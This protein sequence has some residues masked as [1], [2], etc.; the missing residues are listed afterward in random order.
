MSD[1]ITICKECMDYIKQHRFGMR[2]DV[3]S[4]MKDV[5]GDSK[6]SGQNKSLVS[7]V[8]SP[9]ICDTSLVVDLKV[10]FILF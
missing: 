10:Y 1:V 8:T 6:M 3:R 4:G 7:A 5:T 2:E 9:P